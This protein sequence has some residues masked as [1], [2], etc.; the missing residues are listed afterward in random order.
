MDVFVDEM[1]KIMADPTYFLT[2]TLDLEFYR[3]DGTTLWAENTF[4]LIR[5]KDG[6]LESS[7]VRAETSPSAS[8]PRR[9]IAGSWSI[10]SGWRR[11]R[12]W[13]YWPAVLP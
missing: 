3:K 5:D 11:W 12:L 4:S 1:P 2:R 6:N 9:K 10:C 7:C 8:E 13:D